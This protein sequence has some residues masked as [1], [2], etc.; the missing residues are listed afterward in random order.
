MNW[1]GNHKVL[2]ALSACGIPQ[3]DGFVPRARCD[4]LTRQFR[5]IRGLIERIVSLK[6]FDQRKLWTY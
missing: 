2:D 3:F 1:M 5:A 4:E 6:L